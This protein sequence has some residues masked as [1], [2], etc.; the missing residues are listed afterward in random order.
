D[1]IGQTAAVTNRL[2]GKIQEMMTDYE[3]ARANLTSLIGRIQEAAGGVASTSQL[4]GE[5]SEQTG[6]VVA[7]V[8]AAVQGIAAGAQET[9]RS[10]QTT[11]VAVEQL[12]QAIDG[13]ARGA[14][15]Q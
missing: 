1:E 7:Q 11:N 6:A 12:A 9:S 5:A 15:D 14:G 8:T 10:S 4:L 2:L 3:Q 13:I